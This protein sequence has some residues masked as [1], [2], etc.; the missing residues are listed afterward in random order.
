MARTPALTV[1]TLR[2][3]RVLPGASDQQLGTL[4]N[5]MTLERVTR[6]TILFT[7]NDPRELVYLLVSGAVK[8]S[9][10][11]AKGK[12][13]LLSVLAAG[14]FFGP[15]TLLPGM[16]HVFQAQAS[17]DC[18]VGVLRPEAFVS[19]VLGI[20][21]PAFRVAVGSLG[22]HWALLLEQY[23]QCRRDTVQQRIARILRELSQRFGVQDARGT[24]LSVRLTHQELAE[25]VG[26]ARQQVTVQLQELERRGGILRE[27]GKLIV[28]KEML[29]V[30]SQP[31]AQQHLRAVRPQ[32]VT[33]L[34]LRR[35]PSRVAA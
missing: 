33:T 3:M 9:R 14:E 1:P 17:S 23:T 4:L 5:Q 8:L 7:K 34:P 13:E 2:Q 20:S 24:I 22:E 27:D 31:A 18:W 29:D 28:R 32:R 6:R 12:A 25:L 15:T 35:H 19:T 30:L 16:L 11:T 10:C 21:L 26:A